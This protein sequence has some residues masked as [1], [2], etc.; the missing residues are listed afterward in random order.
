MVL[1]HRCPHYGGVPSTEV[2][3][4]RKCPRYGGVPTTEVSP[5]R[6]CPHYGGVPSTEVSPLRK[7]PHYRGVPSTEVSPLRRCPHYGGVPTTEVS[8]LRRCPQF[9]GALVPYL[10]QFSISDSLLA[11]SSN[12][13]PICQPMESGKEKPSSFKEKTLVTIDMLISSSI[14]PSTGQLANQHVNI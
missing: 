10:F 7:C 9:R 5:L 12:P 11:S 6:K 4:L 8:P 14:L 13:F 1:L 2:S 3:P